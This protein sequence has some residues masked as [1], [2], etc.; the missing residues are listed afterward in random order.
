MFF[1]TSGALKGTPRE[2]KTEDFW[3][4]EPLKRALAKMGS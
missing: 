1:T 3:Y 4:F 2:L